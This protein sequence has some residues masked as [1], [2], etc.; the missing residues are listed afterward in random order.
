ME[1]LKTQDRLALAT[2]NVEASMLSGNVRNLKHL[3][4]DIGV[5]LV[6]A[7]LA[8]VALLSKVVQYY[9]F[10]I[11]DWDTGI[12]SNVIWNLISGNGFYS[13]VLNHNHLGDHFSPI[14]A[15]F[16]P[17]FIISPSPVWLLAAQG[18]AVGATY[19]LLY[20]VAIKIFRDENISFAKPLALL[21]VLWAFLYRPLTSALLFEFHPSTLATP[22]VAASVLALRHGSDRTLWLLVAVLLLSKENAPLAVLGLGC[23]AGLVLFRPRLCLALGAVAGGSA[24]LTMGVVMPLFR[25]E[26]WGH[27]S[28]LD[29]FAEWA[30]KSVYLLA[31]VKA[32]AFLPLAS[33]RSLICAAPLVGLNLSVAFPS[34][35]S[36]SYQYDDFASV[37][38]LVAAMHGTVVV[39]RA[40]GCALKSRRAI[41]AACV[42]IASLAL[43]LEQRGRLPYQLFTA[44]LSLEPAPRSAT[45][46]VRSA[47]SYLR[48]F[49]PSDED[50]QLE[51]ELAAYRSLPFQIG[52]AAQQALGPYLSA[53]KR[54]VPI[55]LASEGVDMRRLKPRDKILITPIADA[56][57]FAAL[58]HLFENDAGLTRVHASPVLHVYEVVSRQR[59]EFSEH[60]PN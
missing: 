41:A 22:L 35:Y 4:A 29:P 39:L 33:W 40:I 14:I 51:Q 13:D 24:A 38:L 32:L 55:Y 49:W 34:Q 27:Y 5:V 7:I 11:H 43:L 3:F 23:Y 9:G 19:V 48:R 58:E 44:L 8:I 57:E 15:L 56:I 2:G 42:F 31:L 20:F 54:Y 53:R 47:F 37:F 60:E 26:Q 59:P 50:R 45:T 36:S 6:L 30:D 52:I 21:F 10:Q 18:L 17:F 12:Y 46:D 25:T 1:K 28:R 16:A